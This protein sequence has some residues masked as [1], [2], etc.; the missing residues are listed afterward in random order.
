LNQGAHQNRIEDW[1]RDGR[2]LIDD[3]LDQKTGYDLWVIPLSGGHRPFAWLNTEFSETNARFSPNGQWL[4]YVSDESRRYE[5][6]VQ[7]FPEHDGKWQISTSG[8]DWPVWSRDGRELYFISADDKTMAVDIK[9]S[10][11]SF[12]AGVPK[13]LFPVLAQEQYNVSKDGRFLI[14]VPDN[15]NAAGVP[16]TVVKHW[17]AGIEN[18]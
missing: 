4:A 12:Q 17:Q 3:V 8:G 7:S 1:S 2:W 13:E 16:L 18:R 9:G 6:Y 14:H 5:I 10:G 15:Q 11:T